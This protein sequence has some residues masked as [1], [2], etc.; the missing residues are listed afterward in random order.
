MARISKEQGIY[1]QAMEHALNVAKEQGIEELE[2]EVRYR[3]KTPMPLN[4][5]RNELRAVIRSGMGKEL[6]LIATSLAWTVQQDLNF[7]PS[8]VF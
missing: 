1:A 2:R 3:Q 5:N 4:V 8:M 7:P 6:M